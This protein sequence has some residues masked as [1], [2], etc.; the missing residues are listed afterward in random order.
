MNS[1]IIG[2]T[3]NHLS[4]DEIVRLEGQVHCRLSGRLRG[5][6]LQ[7]EGSGL[8]LAGRAPSYHVKQLAQHAV[9]EATSLAIL[10]NEIEVP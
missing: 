5:F 1:Q 10:A 9:M 2:V 6:R 3:P 8:I 4:Q 7:V